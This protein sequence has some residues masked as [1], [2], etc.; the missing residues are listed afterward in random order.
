MATAASDDYRS[1]RGGG[2][3]WDNF[4]EEEQYHVYQ[5]HGNH[6]GG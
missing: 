4:S 3:L 6:G 2:D 1:L 5:H